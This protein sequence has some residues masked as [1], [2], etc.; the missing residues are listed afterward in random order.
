MHTRKGSIFVNDNSI[1]KE[2]NAVEKHQWNSRNSQVWSLSC[3]MPH[4]IPQQSS[5]LESSPKIAKYLDLGFK[6][7][8]SSS[9]TFFFGWEG[10]FLLVFLSHCR[11]PCCFLYSES[12]PPLE[13]QWE[14][15]CTQADALVLLWSHTPWM[16]SRAVFW[17]SKTFW[18]GPRLRIFF[19]LMF[20]FHKTDFLTPW[21]GFL[22][23]KTRNV[24]LL[25]CT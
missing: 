17:S 22:I 2:K 12:L 16:I 5:H 10:G 9:H 13:V 14:F 8:L 25:L 19:S 1:S 24:Q 7:N 4:R 23:A 3:T 15:H 18:A 21:M 20:Y 6:F 11:P